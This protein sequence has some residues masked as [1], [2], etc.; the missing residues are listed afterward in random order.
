MAKQ[1][2][3]MI[4]LDPLAWLKDEAEDAEIIEADIAA[5]KAKPKKK[6]A[7]KKTTSKKLVK[8]KTS[9][10]KKTDE[11]VVF[12][13][14]AVQDISSV[15]AIHSELKELLSNE[16]IILDG[17]QV[18]R[19]D[20]ASLQLIYSF[21][22]EARIKGIK[23]SWRSPSDVLRNNAKLLGMEDALQLSNAA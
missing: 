22:E 19:I 8:E 2:K 23:V 21:I 16:N 5:S 1:K 13:I 3:S 4:G 6:T 11:D 15:S 20:G 10:S 7:A 12:K 18:E 17:E 14:Q 9:K